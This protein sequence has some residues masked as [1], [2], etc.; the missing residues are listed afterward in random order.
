MKIKNK[1]IEN[2]FRKSRQKLSILVTHPEFKKRIKALRKKW[3]IPSDGFKTEKQ[4]KK[5][6]K[7]IIDKSDKMLEKKVALSKIPI[8]E[9]NKDLRN[10]II[11]FKLPSH[12]LSTI[13]FYIKFNKIA[14]PE[15]FVVNLEYKPKFKRKE[16]SIQI[17]SNTTI[18][19]IKRA[20]Q[21][22][23]RFK[24]YLP[25]YEEGRFREVPTLEIQKKAYLLKKEG[26]TLEQIADLF[27]EKGLGNFGYVEISVLINRYR[28]KL[29]QFNS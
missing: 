25:D 9:F 4:S 12:Y 5:W 23:Q 20:W 18:K 14:T 8:N 3:K 19:D 22:V 16:L 28:K 26:K 17:F 27:Q 1:D 2:R 15:N 11:F 6:H 21:R 24:K 10:I 7:S 13:E 29:Q